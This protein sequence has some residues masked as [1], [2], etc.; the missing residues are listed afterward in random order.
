MANVS[1][2]VTCGDEISKG[3]TISES[4]EPWSVDLES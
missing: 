2:D 1:D 4:F 3:G